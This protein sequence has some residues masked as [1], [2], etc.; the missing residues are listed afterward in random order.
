MALAKQ[1]QDTGSSRRKSNR[2]GSITRR[3]VY[4]IALIP[5]VP[6]VSVSGV[7]LIDRWLGLGSFDK[8]RWFHLFFSVLWVGATIAIWRRTVIWTMGRKWLTALI[9]L[10]P[11][12]QVTYGQPLWD[13][14]CVSNDL[15]RVGQH[16]VGIGIW[17]WLIVWIW[18]GLEKTRMNNEVKRVQTAQLPIGPT[19]KRLVA[20]IATIPFMFGVFVIMGVAFEQFGKLRDPTPFAFAF[21]SLV[22]LLLWVL[23]WRRMVAWSQTVIRQTAATAFVCLIVPVSAQLVFWNS[24]GHFYQAVLA[25]LA[26][27]GWGGWMIATIS[28][29]PMVVTIGATGEMTPRCL[30][31]GYLLTGLTSTRCPECGDEPTID[32]LW[33]ATAGEL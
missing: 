10:I 11:F 22:G 27:A 5:I 16:E 25:C 8:F 2:L 14:G 33:Q 31:C 30:R 4:A 18:W 9:N 17:S 1:D 7:V 28:R 29:W 13:A 20:S 21:A 23:I 32:A 26:V 12:V 24:A 15:L 6:A 19:A 3:I